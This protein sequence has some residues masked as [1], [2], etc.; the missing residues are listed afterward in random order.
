VADAITRGVPPRM[1]REAG[2]IVRRRLCP[3]PTMT[4][5]EVV[6]AEAYLWAIIR[7]RCTSRPSRRS[8]AFHPEEAQLIK[9][10]NQRFLLATIVADMQ[11]V[12]R[13]DRAILAE[14]EEGWAHRIS[15]VVMEEFRSKLTQG[16]FL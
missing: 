14:L 10:M 6:R 7:R 2:D 4:Y 15:P 11:M 3:G 1:A 12:G 13:D 8:S 5:R 16:P 9:Q